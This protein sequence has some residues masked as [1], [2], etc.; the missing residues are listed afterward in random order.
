MKKF[1]IFLLMALFVPLA[2]NGQ[3]TTV[4]ASKITAKTAT[5]TGSANE[6]WNVSITISNTSGLNQNVTNGYAQYGTQRNYATKGTF[7]TSGISGTI[8]SIEVDCASYQGNGTVSVTV[9]GA[10]FGSSQSI[11]SWSN[12]AGGTR[13]F[14]GSASGEIVVTMTNG[15]S[16]H[17]AMYIKSITVTYT[18]TTPSISLDPASATGFTGFT[19]S[20]IAQAI[21]V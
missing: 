6:T 16:T 9:G 7:S 17:R 13:T 15:T 14:T 21:P 20:P 3:S 5:W 1:L 2:M 10:A 8:T 18:S 4:T 11:P 12:N 19:T